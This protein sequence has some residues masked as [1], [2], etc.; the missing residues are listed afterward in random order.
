MV[1]KTKTRLDKTKE[2][3]QKSQSAENEFVKNQVELSAE[4]QK[5][6]EQKYVTFK[7]SYKS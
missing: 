2:I 3:K 1:I 5:L 6:K 4:F 7:F